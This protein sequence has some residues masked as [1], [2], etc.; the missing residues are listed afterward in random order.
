MID[1][2]GEEYR[3]TRAQEGG[4]NIRCESDPRYFFLAMQWKLEF[5]V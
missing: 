2:K 3:A 5:M 1:I 4:N